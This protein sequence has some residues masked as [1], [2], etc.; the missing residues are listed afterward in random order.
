[1]FLFAEVFDARDRPVED[2][3]PVGG[4]LYVLYRCERKD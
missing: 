3:P 2:N 4:L 1:M